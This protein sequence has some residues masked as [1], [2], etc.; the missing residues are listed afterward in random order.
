MKKK[1]LTF[2]ILPFISLAPV[3]LAVSCSQ[4]S[5]IKQKEQKYIDLS[6]NKGIDEGLKLAGVDKNSP[7]AKKAIEEIKKTNEGFAK[8][9]LDAIKQS[10]KSDDEYEKALDQA[11]KELE[12]SNKK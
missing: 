11:I 2:S 6:V 4:Q 5:R 8:V 10:A 7:E 9:A 1:L 12:K 3:A